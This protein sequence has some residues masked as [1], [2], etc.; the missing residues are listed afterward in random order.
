MV[1]SGFWQGRRRGC[2]R[3]L[4]SWSMKMVHWGGEEKK[5]WCLL[6]LSR[7]RENRKMVPPSL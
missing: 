6:D 4:D 1:P 7:Q 5:I 3:V 2:K